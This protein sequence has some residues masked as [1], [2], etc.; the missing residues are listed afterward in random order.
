VEHLAFNVSRATF[1][2]APARLRERGI[3]FIQRDRGS[4][5]RSTCMIP[6]GS[7]SS[8]RATKFETPEGFRAAEVLVKAYALRLER[9][10]PHI[11]EVHVADAIELLMAMRQGT[12][13]PGAVTHAGS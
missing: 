2:L 3:E 6:T 7:K 11:T 1:T 10:D 12:P 13:L 8:W 4:W 5:I 9:R